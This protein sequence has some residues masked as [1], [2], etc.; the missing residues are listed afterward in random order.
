MLTKITKDH[1]RTSLCFLDLKEGQL[2]QIVDEE[3]RQNGHIIL[4]SYIGVI[5][6]TDPHQT[7]S[8]NGRG[9]A[10]RILPVG[11]EVHLTQVEV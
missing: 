9:Y 2:A 10:I 4:R 3:C 7:W 1:G 5:S 11:A 8:G 6:L